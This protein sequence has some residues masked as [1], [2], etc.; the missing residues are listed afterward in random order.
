[1]NNAGGGISSSGG[2]L[3]VAQSTISN[4]A[5]GGISVTSSEFDITNTFIVGNGSA[6]GDF[7]GV[8]LSQTNVGTR[9]F[10][11]NTVS[12]NVGAAGNSLGVVCLLVSQAVTFSNNIVFG[13][14][15]GNGRTQVGGDADCNWTFSDIGDT[16]AGAGNLNVD[17]LFV[18]PAQGNFH[19]QGGSLA[20]NAA[21]PNATLATDGDGDPRPEGARRDMGA[22]EVR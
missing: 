20:R 10:E 13:N 8:L 4:N 9:R 3:T 21:D 1:L 5:G 6:T 2:S 22:D 12:E 14:Q 19:L 7:G 17:P 16:V 18:D 15:V 11:F